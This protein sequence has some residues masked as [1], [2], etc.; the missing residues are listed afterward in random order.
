MKIEKRR[1]PRSGRAG[2]GDWHLPI[3]TFPQDIDVLRSRHR[4]DRLQFRSWAITLHS[5][6]TPLC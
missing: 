5:G 2:L 6:R 4:V 1:R 3:L